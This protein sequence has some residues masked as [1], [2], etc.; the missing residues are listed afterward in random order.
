MEVANGSFLGQN[1]ELK[2]RIEHLQK[3]K[4]FLFF[5]TLLLLAR[6]PK[7][8]LLISNEDV[9]DVFTETAMGV[10]LNFRIWSIKINA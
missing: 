10:T 9:H 5:F 3:F 8:Q 4:N 1:V 7:N 2:T 6:H